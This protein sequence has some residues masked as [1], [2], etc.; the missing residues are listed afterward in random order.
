MYKIELWK[1]NIGRRHCQRCQGHAIMIVTLNT[2]ETVRD[3]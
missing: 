1:T 2:A 3:T